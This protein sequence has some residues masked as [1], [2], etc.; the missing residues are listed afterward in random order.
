MII[1]QAAGAATVNPFFPLLTRENRPV[2]VVPWALYQ[3]TLIPFTII[4]C[5]LCLYGIAMT[6]GELYS[7]G[8]FEL[9]SFANLCFAFVRTMR[10]RKTSKIH[11]EPDLAL[12]KISLLADLEFALCFASFG[13]AC[14]V[15]LIQDSANYVSLFFP[16][17]VFC[18]IF[19]LIPTLNS[20]ALFSRKTLRSLAPGK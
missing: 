14:L 5:C 15:I 7:D 9:L 18:F 12:Q 13:I 1:I 16:L 11:V 20:L 17:A 4:G 2:R 10:F 6:R 8:R 3:K 19:A